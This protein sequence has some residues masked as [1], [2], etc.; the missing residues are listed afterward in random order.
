MML[1]LLR[2]LKLFRLNRMYRVINALKRQYPVSK[3]FLTSFELLLTTVLVGHWICCF[4]YFVGVS[5][6][7]GL[8][9]DF[10]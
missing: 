1:R 9:R 4:W 2:L 8:R 6:N 3:V 10:E 5:S 7:G